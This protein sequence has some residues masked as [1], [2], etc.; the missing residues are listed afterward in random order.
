MRKE[1][2]SITL[3]QPH[4]IDSILTDLKL[5]TSNAKGR[6]TPALSSVLLH[7]DLEGDPFDESFH[8]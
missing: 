2:G 5:N 7:Q 4:L 3:T 8:Y 1:D 6:M